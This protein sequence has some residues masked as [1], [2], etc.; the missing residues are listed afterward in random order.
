M[1]FLL[2]SRRPL[3]PLGFGSAWRPS[4]CGRL[5]QGFT[6]KID[7]GDA[8]GSAPVVV[9][10]GRVDYLVAV[11]EIGDLSAEG[12][13]RLTRPMSIN[14][15]EIDDIGISQTRCGLIKSRRCCPSSVSNGGRPST[16]PWLTREVSSDQAFAILP[17]AD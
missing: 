2:R 14:S 11:V 7:L 4:N 3:E 12:L 6:S 5:D 1:W 17:A 10:E 13:L 9:I 15:I 16:T 8:D